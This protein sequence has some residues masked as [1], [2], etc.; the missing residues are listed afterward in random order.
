MLGDT[1][2][3]PP[4]PLTEAYVWNALGFGADFGFGYDF[5][6][7]RVAYRLFDCV[8]R[9]QIAVDE[10]ATAVAEGP[11]RIEPCN[12][13]IEGPEEAVD[14]AEG[15]DVTVECPS[16]CRG[17]FAVRWDSGSTWLDPRGGATLSPG[18]HTVHLSAPDV[19]PAESGAA[20]TTATLKLAADQPSGTRASFKTPITIRRPPG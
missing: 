6:G 11:M 15:F 7:E 18:R 16:G 19:E 1:S 8:G 4:V 14:I 9:R 17:N 2:G 5:D 13:T 12:A 20:T 3:S 10:V